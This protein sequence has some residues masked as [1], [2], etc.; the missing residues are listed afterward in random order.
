MD[1]RKEARPEGWV[2]RK[3]QENEGGGEGGKKQETEK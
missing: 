3:A 1:E 2:G